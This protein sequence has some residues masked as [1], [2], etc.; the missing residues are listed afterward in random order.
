MWDRFGVL[1]AKTIDLFIYEWCAHL[2]Q[3]EFSYKA[4][5]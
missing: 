2:A 4:S 5:G 1:L 3:V